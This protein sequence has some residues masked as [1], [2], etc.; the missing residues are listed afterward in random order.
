[1][2]TTTDATNYGSMLSKQTNLLGQIRRFTDRLP[3]SIFDRADTASDPVSAIE[4]T[5]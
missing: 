2:L 1:M 3:K 4:T 5:V